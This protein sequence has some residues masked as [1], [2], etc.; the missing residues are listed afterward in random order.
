MNKVV[1]GDDGSEPGLVAIEWAADEA[2]RRCASLHVVYVATPWLSD[3]PTDP[4][5]ARVREQMLDGG[6]DIVA[7]RRGPCPQPR[8]RPVGDRANR[9]PSRR[10][11]WSNRHR[12]SSGSTTTGPSSCRAS[13]FADAG[14]P[15]RKPR[16]IDPGRIPTHPMAHPARSSG[17]QRA[18]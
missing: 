12:T 2:A 10:K 17:S 16:W 9:W 13:S 15:V 18:A 11:Y 4:G 8:S 1:V 5:A 14:M 6:R 3:V 7:E